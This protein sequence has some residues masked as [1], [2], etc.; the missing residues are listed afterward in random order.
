[1]NTILSFQKH[2]YRVGYTLFFYNLINY[3]INILC[4][5]LLLLGFIIFQWCIAST[6]IFHLYL[7]YFIFSLLLLNHIF[8][9][10]NK[11]QNNYITLFFHLML[12]LYTIQSQID[13]RKFY[14]KVIIYN[15]IK[16]DNKYSKDIECSICYENL[17]DNV[18]KTNCNH[19]Y[20]KYCIETWTKQNDTCPLCRTY[21]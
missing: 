15:F 2:F 5:D 16:V 20:H 4:M 12:Y 3:D 18:I 11:I 6:K 19:L 1:M 10:Q 14:D 13:F 21:L 9:I 7:I 8:F 17:I